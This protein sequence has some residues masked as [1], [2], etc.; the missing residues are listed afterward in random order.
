M[1]D[2]ALVYDFLWD[3]QGD[4]GVWMKIDNQED[5]V[6][7]EAM[8][9]SFD[10]AANAGLGKFLDEYICASQIKLKPGDRVLCIQGMGV[11]SVAK[12]Y[13]KEISRIEKIGTQIPVNEQQEKLLQPR[14]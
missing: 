10:P 7:V 9:W 2:D 12:D 4:L 6:L 14:A 5:L 1:S 11:G 13:L 3:D 8:V